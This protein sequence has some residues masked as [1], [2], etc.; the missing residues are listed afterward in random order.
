M[1]RRKLYT[2]DEKK[3]LKHYRNQIYYNKKVV[4]QLEKLGEAE[5][6]VPNGAD[7]LY[8]STITLHDVRRKMRITAK[9]TGL[10]RDVESTDAI[11]DYFFDDHI[12]FDVDFRQYAT[13]DDDFRKAIEP[14]LEGIGFGTI[15]QYERYTRA[16]S[17]I[18]NAETALSIL[19]SASWEA[20]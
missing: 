4:A 7:F 9:D 15:E 20:E 5:T 16:K 1:G 17:K 11:Y 12:Y 6:G 19:G 8:G 13:I 10:K 2:D 3:V 14:W 18:E